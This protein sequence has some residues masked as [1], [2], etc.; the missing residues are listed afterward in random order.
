MQTT[1]YIVRTETIDWPRSPE[2]RE[3]RE[4]EFRYDEG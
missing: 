2:E 4:H 3:L 1:G